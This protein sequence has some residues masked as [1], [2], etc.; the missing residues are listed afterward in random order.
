MAGASI[1]ATLIE[2]RTLLFGKACEL[3]ALKYINE[4]SAVRFLQ[5]FDAAAI[6]D[7][8]LGTTRQIYILVAGANGSDDY[9]GSGLKFDKGIVVAPTTTGTGSTA[10]AD[11]KTHVFGEVR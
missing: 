5:V 6:A 8:T 2:S 1:S 11:D 9:F 10:A 4:D 3:T 7:V